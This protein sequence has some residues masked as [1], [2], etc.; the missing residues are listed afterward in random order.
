MEPTETNKIS[1]FHSGKFW[2][3]AMMIMGAIQVMSI[4][5]LTQSTSSRT[6]PMFLR[7]PITR[8]ISIPT[9]KYLWANLRQLICSLA[10]CCLCPSSSSCAGLLLRST[11]IEK[12]KLWSKGRSCIPPGTCFW[13]QQS[14]T[15]SHQR[16]SLWLWTSSPHR[17][18]RSW[19]GEWLPPLSSSLS[20]TSRNLFKG[21]NL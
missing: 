19:R 11:R 16:C 18:I 6:P 21:G 2:I 9:S 5:E 14:W 13:S 20:P 10:K 12:G 1:L 7:E 3:P 8:K 17:P 15:C 4:F